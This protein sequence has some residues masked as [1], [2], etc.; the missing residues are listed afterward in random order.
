MQ[1]FIL[2]GFAVSCSVFED[3]MELDDTLLAVLKSAKKL[4]KLDGYVCF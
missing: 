4:Q 3:L 2:D 1:I